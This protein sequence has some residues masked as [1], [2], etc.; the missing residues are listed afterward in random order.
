MGDVQAVELIEGV[1]WGDVVDHPLDLGGGHMPCWTI[2]TR[3]LS[4]FGQR[5]LVLT[6]ANPA[7]AELPAGIF[8]FLVTVGRL[9]GE[10]QLVGSGAITAFQTPGPFDF[11]EFLG[12][13]YTPATVEHEIRLPTDALQAVLLRDGELEMAIRCSC[14]RVLARLGEIARFCPWPFWSDPSRPSAYQSGDADRSLLSKVPRLRF[15][16]LDLSLDGT[17][18]VATLDASEAAQV[19]SELAVRDFATVVPDPDATS[20]ATLVWS[21]DQVEP[22]AISSDPTR[23]TSVSARFLMIVSDQ[24]QDQ[25]E[26]RFQEDGWSLLATPT[27]ACTLIDALTQAQDAE[28]FCDDRRISVKVLR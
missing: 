5:E 17:E 1:L 15:G 9:S 4:T 21:P 13:V 26:I 2:T 19:A 3:G 27:R 12:A 16:R 23:T 22:T 11:G 6:I 10:G 7:E 25:D 8:D 14:W 20:L 28:L 24:R 18:L